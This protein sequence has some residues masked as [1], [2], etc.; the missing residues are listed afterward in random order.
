MFIS[1]ETSIID[2]LELIILVFF[3]LLLVIVPRRIPDYRWLNICLIQRQTSNFL[4]FRCRSIADVEEMDCW[5]LLRNILLLLLYT[6]T[7]FL[8]LLVNGLVCQISFQRRNHSSNVPLGTTY[9]YLLN[10]ALADALSGLMILIQFLFCS[11]YFLETY[12]FSS[13]LCIGSKSIQILGYNTSTLTICV[14]ALDRYRLV[15]NPFQ[16][17]HQRNTSRAIFFTWFFSGLFSASCL[18]SMKVQTYFHSYEN[19]IA[20]QILFPITLNALSTE[21]IRQI[22]IVCLIVCFHL[23]PFLTITILCLLTMRKITRRSI[24]GVQQ[25]RTFEQSRTRSTRLLMLIVLVF[26]VSH[27]PINCIY[28]RDLF[29]VSN[30]ASTRSIRT[31]KCNDSTM[32]L[33]FYWLGISSCCY[34][35]II[36]SWFNRKYRTLLCHCCRSLIC[37]RQEE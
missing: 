7:S 11:K 5:I 18:L 14:I 34:N 28:L 37:C 1:T 15:Q 8:S 26:T 22:R 13:Y 30:S 16:Q 17:F 10:L 32:Y 33:F 27:L 35:P 6:L 2:S 24:I 4:P 25:F 9:I 19:F 3:F 29:L 31:V 21:Y 20:C 23:I 36:Y 12:S